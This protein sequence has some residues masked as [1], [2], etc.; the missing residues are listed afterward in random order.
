MV[1]LQLHICMEASKCTI[2]TCSVSHTCI[3]DPDWE[4]IQILCALLE[5]TEFF[6]VSYGLL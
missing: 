4:N 3:D 1:P 5:G 6:I 2:H